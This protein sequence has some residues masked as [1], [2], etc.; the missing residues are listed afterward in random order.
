M[1]L[2]RREFFAGGGAMLAAGC[3]SCRSAYE[4]GGKEWSLDGRLRLRMKCP[5][6]AEPVK[7]WV[8]G[9]THL[10][11]HDGR[12][13]A[14][15]GNYRRMA[16]WPGDTA[17]FEKMLAEAKTAGID[18]LVL[19]GDIISFPTLANVEF[20]KRTL[21]ESG[22]P[23]IYTA[24]NHDWHFE[25]DPGS[26]PEQRVR[27]IGKRLSGLYPA[28]AN[29]LCHSRVVKGVRFVMIDDS[30]YLMTREQVD[31]WKAEA[32]RGDPIVLSMHIPIWTEGWS[33]R[34]CLGCPE[35]GA[36][37]DP[38][39]E[40]ERRERW[41]AKATPETFEFVDAVLST[42]NLMAVMTG[43]IHSFMAAR[44]R[45]QDMFSVPANS[46][47]DRLELNLVPA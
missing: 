34:S 43:H 39:W 32:S 31:F 15:A 37:I 30:D 26:S 33:K 13:D 9:D 8:A 44:V 47:G 24:G 36:A 28:D 35:W 20:V 40:V 18:L 21:D 14:Y 7:A 12:D 41:P 45:G 2:N 42:P 23:W 4:V 19:A 1:R 17:A 16:Q 11:L 10:A 46:K 3:V 22:V 25:G 27:W 38:Y 6:L 5:G 29:P